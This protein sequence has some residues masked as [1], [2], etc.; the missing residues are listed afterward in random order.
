MIRQARLGKVWTDRVWI[1]TLWRGEYRLGRNGLAVLGTVW[2][3]LAR[4]GR[5]GKGGMKWKE[6]R[7][8]ST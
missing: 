4:Y 6:R 2:T 1:G 7:V 8:Y 5:Y 3:G